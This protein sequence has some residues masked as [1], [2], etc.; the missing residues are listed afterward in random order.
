[1]SISIVSISNLMRTRKYQPPLAWNVPKAEL[2]RPIMS[3]ARWYNPGY[4]YS[5]P[6]D[7]QN[8]LFVC[9]DAVG[10]YT[11][12]HARFVTADDEWVV[13]KLGA[14]SSSR[15]YARAYNGEY[16]S[17]VDWVFFN[18]D[19]YELPVFDGSF[20]DWMASFC[21]FG[22]GSKQYDIPALI[23]DFFDQNGQWDG[24]VD[25]IYSGGEGA[26]IVRNCL[27]QAVR[28]EYAQPLTNVDPR[29]NDWIG[30]AKPAGVCLGFGDEYLNTSA[31]D[32]WCP[33][34]SCIGQSQRSRR[35]PHRQPQRSHQQ[36][37]W[38]LRPR[39]SGLQSSKPRTRG[40]RT[41]PR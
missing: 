22:K 7:L 16:G 36:D 21:A 33:C 27:L 32:G 12:T 28:V 14:K 15:L 4:S 37:L 25:N 24:D 40:I 1:M 9:R 26:K 23:A 13:L 38:T 6:E 19:A 29:L 20:T 5:T 31:R 35:A 39:V 10:D 8:K 11:W 34:L 41:N 2:G 3:A 17:G 30:S 18:V